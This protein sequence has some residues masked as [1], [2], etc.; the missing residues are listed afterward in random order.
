MLLGHHAVPFAVGNL[1]VVGQAE[2]RV[3]LEAVLHFLGP[4]IGIGVLA[5]GQIAVHGL[6]IV[7]VVE[8]GSSLNG[9]QNKLLKDVVTTLWQGQK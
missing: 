8:V 9:E 5:L 6:G 3:A 2:Q 1:L 7:H 4:D